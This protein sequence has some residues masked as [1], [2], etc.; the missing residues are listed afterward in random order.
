MCFPSKKIGVD[1]HAL[2]R[3]LMNFTPHPPKEKNRTCGAEITK[4]SRS[5]QP[6]DRLEKPKSNAP[7]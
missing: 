3:I 1:V 2:R 5:F 6:M 7:Q 4:N